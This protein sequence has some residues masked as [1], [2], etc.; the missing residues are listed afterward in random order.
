MQYT[1]WEKIETEK[2]SKTISRQM[3]SGENTTVARI[4]LA[5]GAHVP[6]HS[7]ESEQFSIILSGA[8]KFI[9]DDAEAVVRAGEI[10]YIPSNKPHAAEALEDTVDLDVFSP[11]REDWIRKDDAYLRG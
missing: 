7:H 4:F 3:L 10:V 11:R 9:F 2:L 8:L 1:S 5:R 6:R